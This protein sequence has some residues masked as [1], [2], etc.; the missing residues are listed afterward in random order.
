MHSPLALRNNQTGIRA[1]LR[2]AIPL[3]LAELGWMAMGVVDTIMAGGLPDSA[4]AIGATSVG[5]AAFYGLGIFG[6][7]L[8]SGMDAI[9][10]QAYGARDHDGVKRGLASGLM[11]ALCV[12]PFL[13]A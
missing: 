1:L 4:V 10:S 8:M 5:N 7:G 12:M 3:A 13:M 6:L 9:V 11:L 2:I